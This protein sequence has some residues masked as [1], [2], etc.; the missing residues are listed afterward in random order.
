M[1][2]KWRAGYCQIGNMFTE[3]C[4]DYGHS[5]D[6]VARRLAERCGCGGHDGGGFTRA[7]A[8]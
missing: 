3:C 6:E 5:A 7:V 4:V 1:I 2:K 8:C